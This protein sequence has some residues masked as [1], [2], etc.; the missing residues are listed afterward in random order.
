MKKVFIP[1][2]LVLF[3]CSKAEELKSKQVF[4]KVEISNSF[5]Q[6]VKGIYDTLYIQVDC[7]KTEN[8]IL[9]PTETYTPCYDVNFG[10]NTWSKTD[11]TNVPFI[12][13]ARNIVVRSGVIKFTI[14]GHVNCIL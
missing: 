12:I 10:Y 2:V 9:I 8:I 4:A 1:I 5:I 3:S 14:E 13:K 6:S 11:T 7:A